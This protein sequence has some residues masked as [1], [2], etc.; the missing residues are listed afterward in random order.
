M[1]LSIEIPKERCQTQR[2]FQ[3]KSQPLVPSNDKIDNSNNDDN[4]GDSNID[5]NNNIIYNINRK[6]NRKKTDHRNV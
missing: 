2:I 4:N 3:N 6:S 5:N 1:N